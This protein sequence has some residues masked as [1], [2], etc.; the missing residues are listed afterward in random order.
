MYNRYIPEEVEY[1][2]VNGQQPTGRPHSPQ[3]DGEK[4]GKP[5][6]LSSLLNGGVFSGS[7]SL[8]GILK[9]LNLGELIGD[10]DIGDILLLLILIF[11]LLEGDDHMELIIALG[12][13]LLMGLG[14]KKK[15]AQSEED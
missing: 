6:D 5:F 3:H 11:L 15:K 10:V 8:G 9:S 7:D 12:L 14:D 4:N 13:L 2:P 1:I